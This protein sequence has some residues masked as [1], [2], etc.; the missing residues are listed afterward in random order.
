M[1]ELIN[2]FRTVEDTL[3]CILLSIALVLLLNASAKLKG[4]PIRV[5]PFALFWGL[6]P[7]YIWKSM[8]MIR[9]LFMEKATNPDLYKTV[10]DTGEVFESLSGLILAVSFIFILIQLRKLS[11]S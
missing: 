11:A 4:V 10:H 9:R 8:G 2:N 3:A 1:A 7:L 6:V 5:I